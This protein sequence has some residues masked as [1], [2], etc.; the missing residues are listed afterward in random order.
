MIITVFML[1]LGLGSL[2]GGW[3]SSR[4][5]MRLL[6]AFGCIE[7]LVGIFGLASLWIFHWVGTFTA[8]A[9]TT[10]GRSTSL[11]RG[12]SSIFATPATMA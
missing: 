3:L 11:A 8:G 5:G 4:K 2:A 7:F 10:G 1:G 12:W 9:S 6:L